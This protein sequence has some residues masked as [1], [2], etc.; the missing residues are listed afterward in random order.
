MIDTSLIRRA[1]G[2]V[3][4]INDRLDAAGHVAHIT[5]WAE[6]DPQQ[7]AELAVTLASLISGP[8]TADR[9]MLALAE[10]DGLDMTAVNLTAHN[11]YERNR[12]Y[13]RTHPIPVWVS[14]GER[15]YQREKKRRQRARK[16]AA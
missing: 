8:V 12:T 5:A 7:V 9:A 11:A 3:D 4:G 16:G 10:L 13:G 1:A 6:A 14:V 15:L 2:L